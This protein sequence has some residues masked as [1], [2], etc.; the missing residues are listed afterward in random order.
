MLHIDGSDGEGGG[1]VLRTALGLSLATGTPFRIEG[2]RGR[3]KNPGLRRQHLCCVQAAVEVGSA[4]ATGAAMG[5]TALEFHPGPLRSGDFAFAIGSA[6]STG[7]VLQT[8]LPGLLRAAGPSTVRLS[9]GTHNPMAPPFD[10]LEKAFAPV[11]HGMG[12]GLD[13]Q[14]VRHGFWPAGGGVLAAAIAPCPAPT[15]FELV[16]RTDAGPWRARALLS[17]IREEVGV[18]EV[19]ALRQGTG[20]E[21]LRREQVHIEEVA[22]DGPGNALLLEVP[23]VGLCEVFTAFGERGVSAEQVAAALAS[24]VMPFWR[25]GAPVGP[26]LADQLLIPMALAGGGAFR[27]VEPTLH[28]RTN[29]ALIERFLPVRFAMAPDGGDDRAWTV[30]CEPA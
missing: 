4:V 15:P 3:R 5:S 22:A 17:Q 24:A 30:R 25:S 1:Q 23:M 8:V 19:M 13:L 28:C 26:H 9:G 6:G 29:A 16:L 7:L 20:R 21:L 27:T 14:L 2:I 11:L 18:R 10:F 12:I